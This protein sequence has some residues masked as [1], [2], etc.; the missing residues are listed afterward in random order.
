MK[1]KIFAWLG[2]GMLLGIRVAAQPAQNVV[3]VTLDGVRWQE[4]FNGADGRLL[5]DPAY[6]PDTAKA[7]RHF[8][9]ATPQ[10]RRQKLMPFV[11]KTVA[12][13]G[14]LY[15]NRQLQ[16][17]V[18]V[19]NPY[20]FSYPGY[21]ELLAGYVDDRV[22]SNKKIPN[23]N[24]TVLE[25]LN[26]KPDLRGK[27]AVFSSWEV[28][29]A[30]VNESRSGIPANSANEARNADNAVDSLLND[31][32]A[33]LPREWGDGVRADFLTYFT[34]RAYVQRHKPRVLFLSFD[35]TDELAHAGRYFD[36]LTM[37]QSLDRYLGDLWRTMQAMPE[38]RGKTTFMLTTDHGRG[39]QGKARWKS[40][41]TGTGG[42]YQMW[43]AVWGAGVAP[44]G[45]QSGGPVFF[46]HQI[47]ATLAR[48]LGYDFQSD[49]PV[50]PPIDN[51]FA[52]APAR[53][54]P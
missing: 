29:E 21:S 37:L 22:K 24:P 39:Q 46:Q 52:P 3:L 16:S 31:M 53:V 5:F 44:T 19:A 2:I 9:G 35:E 12:E 42:S 28:I 11:W 26:K 4:V 43:L 14:Q 6:S 18:N 48:A 23:P 50:G 25:F 33:L 47:A 8:W 34:A 51:V 17:R 49:K 54:E 1:K 41:G 15:G 27:V 45:E 36:H 38:Y 20:W 40:H 7:R 32:T 10:E 13:Q 30:A